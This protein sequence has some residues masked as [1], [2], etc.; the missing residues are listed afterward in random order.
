MTDPTPTPAPEDPL[1]P[2]AK[3]SEFAMSVLGVASGIALV[4]IGVYSNRDALVDNGTWIVMGSIAGYQLART[5][6]KRG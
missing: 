1:K 3:T 4:T 6:V 5:F 2:G